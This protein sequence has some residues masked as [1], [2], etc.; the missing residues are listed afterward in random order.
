VTQYEVRDASG[1]FVARLDLAYP[2]RKLGIEYEGGHHR[3][4]GVFRHDLRRILIRV[5]SGD[6]L[7][8][9]DSAAEDYQRRVQQHLEVFAGIVL[10][11][12]KVGQTALDQSGEAQPLPG[13]PGAGP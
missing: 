8:S 1:L 10:V 12:D 6:R 5:H 4:R 9:Y 11:D 13:A 2:K 3:G 7:A